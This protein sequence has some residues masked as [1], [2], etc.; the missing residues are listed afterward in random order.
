MFGG[1][2]HAALEVQ[3]AARD[4]DVACEASVWRRQPSAQRFNCTHPDRVDHPPC[5]DQRYV[6][7]VQGRAVLRRKRQHRPAQRHVQ[8]R[9]HR[10]GCVAE[11]DALRDAQRGAAPH[12]RQQLGGLGRGTPRMWVRGWVPFGL[13]LQAVPSR[14]LWFARTASATKNADVEGPEQGPIFKPD[15]SPHTPGSAPA[16]PTPEACLCRR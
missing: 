14:R 13:R 15:P 8:R 9:R 5:H 12:Q 4:W 7:A 6:R 1:A 3:P 11:E 10:L 2:E 16:P